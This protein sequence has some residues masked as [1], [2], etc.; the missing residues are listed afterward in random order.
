MYRCTYM[1]IYSVPRNVIRAAALGLTDSSQVD[2]LGVRCKSPLPLSL[3]PPGQDSAGGEAFRGENFF[4][5]RA[6]H[7][8]P[9]DEHAPP[10]SLSSTLEWKRAQIAGSEPLVPTPRAAKGFHEYRGYSKLRTHPALGPY[11]R[12]MPRSIGP[13]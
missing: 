1:Y 4:G 8:S 3:N 5:R 10:A 9:P 13:S 7:P 11:G 12:S 6:A 2:T